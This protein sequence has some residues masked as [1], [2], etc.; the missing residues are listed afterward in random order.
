MRIAIIYYSSTG[1]T[2]TIAQLLAEGMRKSGATADVLPVEQCDTSVLEHYDKLAFGCP[3]M[4]QEELDDLVFL[5]FFE[6][7]EDDLAG[8]E[9][10]LF[11][12]FGWGDGQW[13]RSWE[14]R[15]KEKGASLF[16]EGLAI[17]E[18]PG[19]ESDACREFGFRFASGES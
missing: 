7:L 16:E 4:G 9:V 17:Q 8:R 13:M 5:P 2:E 10:A 14:A 19:P 18:E 15:V 3:A 1:N 11:G 12:S 6:Q